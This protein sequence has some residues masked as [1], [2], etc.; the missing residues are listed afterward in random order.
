M[1]CFTKDYLGNKLIWWDFVYPTNLETRSRS[2]KLAHMKLHQS[3]H[4]IA[5]VRKAF[6]A[7]K[8][9]SLWSKLLCDDEDTVVAAVFEGKLDSL[10]AESTF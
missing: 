9:L 4:A 7:E 8:R 2:Q 3:D 5:F 1:R 6:E 10:E